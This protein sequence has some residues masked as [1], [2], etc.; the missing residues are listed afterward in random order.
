M[1][2]ASKR[3]ADRST[4][5]RSG[6]SAAAGKQARQTDQ[7]WHRMSDDAARPAGGDEKAGAI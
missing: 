1:F 3:A 5:D 2:C 7:R 6:V 4:G